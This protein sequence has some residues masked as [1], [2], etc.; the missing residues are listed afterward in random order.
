MILFS[1]FQDLNHC[2][3]R[4]M[5]SGTFCDDIYWSCYKRFAYKNFLIGTNM[6]TYV[7]VQNPVF[8]IM[9]SQPTSSNL[10]PEVAMF[11]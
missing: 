8:A 1:L 6:Y 7:R 9:I 10:L 4:L 11:L 2:K 5:L 3:G